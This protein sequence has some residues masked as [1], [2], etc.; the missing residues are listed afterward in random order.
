MGMKY[1][2]GGFNYPYQGLEAT[3]Q[4]RW[5]VVAIVYFIYLSIKFDGVD[6]QKRGND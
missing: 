6:M 1:M 4:T 2:L 5:L 3:R